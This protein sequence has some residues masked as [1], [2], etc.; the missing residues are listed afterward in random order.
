MIQDIIDSGQWLALQ[1]CA[2]RGCNE[3]VDS[4]NRG[5]FIDL[6]KF[7]AI[8]NDKVAS[9]VLEKAPKGNAKYTSPKIQ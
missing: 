3:S 1:T 4:K 7:L 5:N 8:Y 6:I 9:L 2:F